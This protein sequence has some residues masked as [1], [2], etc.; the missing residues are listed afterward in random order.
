MAITNPVAVYVAESNH[1]AELVC[2]R[3][4]QNEIEVHV[5][6]DDSL[7]EL[8][9]RPNAFDP[10]APS[11]GRSIQRRSGARAIVEIPSGAGKTAA[12][13]TK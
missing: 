10:Q 5:T 11:L 3:L 4:E 8:V 12:G 2:L 6:T 13:V 7:V 9:A 1:E